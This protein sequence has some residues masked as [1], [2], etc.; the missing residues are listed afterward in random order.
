MRRNLWLCLHQAQFVA[1]A[2]SAADCL[3]PCRSCSCCKRCCCCC[4]RRNLWLCLHQVQFRAV[5]TSAAD[6]LTPCRCCHNNGSIGCCRR[7]CCTRRNLWGCLHQV[8]FLAVATSAADCLTE[9]AAGTLAIAQVLFFYTCPHLQQLLLRLLLQ[10][11]LTVCCLNSL[12]EGTVHGPPPCLALLHVLCSRLPWR[13][14][15]LLQVALQNAVL[16][17]MACRCFVNH[18]FVLSLYVG[19]LI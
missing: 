5:A 8:Q 4:M 14:L 7:C 3:T 16:L 9:P 10:P 12:E 18:R 15:P 1:V 17:A 6:C 11:V 13:W 2:T 19:K